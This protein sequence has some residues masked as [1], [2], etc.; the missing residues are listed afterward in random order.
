M[1]Y[2]HITLIM[3]ANMYINYTLYQLSKN[4]GSVDT[5]KTVP[6]TIIFGSTN[7][8]HAPRHL[9]VQRLDVMYRYNSPFSFNNIPQFDS[10]YKRMVTS[11]SLGNID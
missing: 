10:N 2:I 3:Y 9:V 7:S 11:Q 1:L 4:F 6:R 5:D 8:C